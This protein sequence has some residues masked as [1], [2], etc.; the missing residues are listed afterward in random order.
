MDSLKI[1]FKQI[2]NLLKII[3]IMTQIMTQIMAQIMAQINI[4]LEELFY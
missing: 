1:Q 3:Y 2:F 4:T